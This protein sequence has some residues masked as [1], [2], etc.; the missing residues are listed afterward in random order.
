LVGNVLESV[1]NV[2]GGFL[3]D[4]DDLREVLKDIAPCSTGAQASH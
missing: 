2:E 1:L 4:N 3:K